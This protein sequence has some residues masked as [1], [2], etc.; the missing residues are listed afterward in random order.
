M[1]RGTK[2]STNL[3]PKNRATHELYKQELQKLDLT[4]GF[5]TK[6]RNAVMQ[7]LQEMQ[8]GKTNTMAG[9][10]SESGT[11]IH[12]IKRL[13]NLYGEG[14]WAKIKSET[15]F[16]RSNG[17]TVELHA[18]IEKVTNRLVELKIKKQ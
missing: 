17:E 18:Y 1:G 8:T 6:E 3:N 15:N 9:F 16:T 10:G 11:P 2:V 12:D 14:N 7:Q 5:S 13:N 4:H